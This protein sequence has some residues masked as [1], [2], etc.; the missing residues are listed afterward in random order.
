[1]LAVQDA[2][3][4]GFD[5]ALLVDEEGIIAEGSGENFFMVQ[6]GNILTNDERDHVLMGI[7]EIRS[8]RWRATWAIRF[9][10]GRCDW[11]NWKLRMRRFHGYSGGSDADCSAGSQTDW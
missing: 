10:S 6:N 5:E 2:V 1:M 7:T 4:R 3:R 9:S 11:K 8:S